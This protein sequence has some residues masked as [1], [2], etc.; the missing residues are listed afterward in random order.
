MKKY[1]FSA[2]SALILSM[3]FAAGVF[4]G[5]EISEA[6]EAEALLPDYLPEFE[7]VKLL[8]VNEA[9]VYTYVAAAMNDFETRIDLTEYD[10]SSIDELSEI[11]SIVKYMHPELYFVDTTYNYYTYDGKIT[12]MAPTYFTTDRNEV[13]AAVHAMNEVIDYIVS[14]TNDSMTDVEKLLTV[15]DYI[16]LHSE[17]DTSLSKFHAKDLLLDGAAVCQ[18]YVSAMYTI[19]ERLGIPGGFVTSDEMNHV[20]NVFYIDGAWY[21]V[22][23][24]YDDPTPDYYGSVSHGSFLKSNEGIRKDVDKSGKPVHYGF[25]DVDGADDTS[26]DESFLDEVTSPVIVLANNWFYIDRSGNIVKYN[27]ITGSSENLYR[28]RDRWQY[29]GSYYWQGVFSGLGYCDGRLFFNGSDAVYSM[30]LDGTDVTSLFTIDRTDSSIYGLFADGNTVYYGT[31]LK[32]GVSVTDKF[33]FET[34]ERTDEKYYYLFDVYSYDGYSY[35]SYVRADDKNMNICAA[36]ITSGHLG[37]FQ[38][39]A[40]SDRIGTSMLRTAESPLTKLIIL[41]DDL[42]PMLPGSYCIEN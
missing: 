3:A 23:V 12:A 15:H 22:D 37:N 1:L 26:Y 27:S 9:D 17:Y 13:N 6:H 14:L 25:E 20:W 19:A 28:I 40:S 18:G 42:C 11:F 29:E 16:V 35:L 2:L 4:A 21:H 39:Y 10:I 31:G 24:T 38:I 8:D 7:E 41:D 32:T 5:A 36:D 33:A 30:E 34:E